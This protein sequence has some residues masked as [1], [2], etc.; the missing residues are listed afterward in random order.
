MASYPTSATEFIHLDTA[1]TVLFPAAA[2]NALDEGCFMLLG[3]IVSLGLV[4]REPEGSHYMT[5]TAPFRIR[6]DIIPSFLQSVWLK[7]NHRLVERFIPIYLDRPYRG[8]RTI[9]IA[10]LFKP[11]ASATQRQLFMQSFDHCC[12]MQLQSLLLDLS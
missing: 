12:K 6:R 1:S 3:T 7:Q 4:T 2:Q 5:S 8:K 10:V 9:S 11:H